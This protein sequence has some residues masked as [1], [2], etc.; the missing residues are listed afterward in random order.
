MRLETL[1]PL[2]I[3]QALADILIVAYFF[4]RIF[5]LIRG[6]RAV[7]LV[8][9]IV[10]LMIATQVSSWL[11][12]AATHQVLQTVQVGL[13]V[14]LP[15]VFQP[16]L[17][18]A[19]EQL[20]RGRLFRTDTFHHLPDIDVERV[21]RELVRGAMI[22][23]QGRIGAL[24]VVERATGLRDYIETGIPVDAQL[25]SALLINVFAPGT[26]L[27][28]GA[29]VVRGDR[30]VAAACFLPLVDNDALPLDLGT[31]H[32]AAVGITEQSD[33][34]ALVVSEETGAVSLAQSGRLIRH[35]DEAGLRKILFD[36][37]RPEPIGGLLT[38][39]DG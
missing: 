22:L 13:L 39:R 26:P 21:V 20:G 12:L 27:H 9:G 34:L 3:A 7:Q 31:R 28:D 38:E 23:S 15:V 4:Y 25:T 11:N 16:E 18:R 37:L 6:T 17:R 5:L 10:I 30:V 29:T 35:L 14:A 32:R 36:A 19:L 1:G 2:G 33:A 24:V 8:K